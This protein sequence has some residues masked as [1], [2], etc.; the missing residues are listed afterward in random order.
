VL[1]TQLSTPGGPAK[2]EFIRLAAGVPAGPEWPYGIWYFGTEGLAEL[3]RR[4][5]GPVIQN[6]DHTYAL[7]AADRTYLASLGI[8]DAQVDG[9]LTTMQASRAGAPPQSR[10][11]L[12]QYA[13]FTG[14]IKHPVLTLDTTV[15]ALVP[16]GHI[17]RYQATVA[18][19]GR[20]D[21]LAT[22]WTNGVG[23]CAFT[24]QQF[25]T[26][27]QAL[28]QWVQT[29]QRPGPFPASQGFV[30]YTPPPWP[31]P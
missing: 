11:Y 24:P 28:Q 16:P 4:A 20:T 6:L 31:H 23:H 10:H 3:E 27:I 12:E 19:A 9:Y 17:N 30:D 1:L 14:K 21:N 5:G 2:L 8:T 25:V 7:S 18:A 26:A 13:D 22:A 29:G 15:D